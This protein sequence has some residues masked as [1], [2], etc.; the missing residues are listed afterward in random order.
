MNINNVITNNNQEKMHWGDGL[1]LWDVARNKIIGL[2]TL[3]IYY[4]Q[5]QDADLKKLI[6]D[7][8]N[9]IVLPHI[10][11]VQNKLQAEGFNIPNEPELSR[12]LY[13]QPASAAPNTMIKDDEIAMSLRELSRLT[14]S[15]ETEALRNATRPDIREMLHNIFEADNKAYGKVVKLQKDKGWV[16]IPPY[17]H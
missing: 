17:F 6:E 11:Q 10:K 14:M 9:N 13:D 1:G 8:V 7:G 4:S 12:K 3:A 2:A 15:L 16:D 5:A